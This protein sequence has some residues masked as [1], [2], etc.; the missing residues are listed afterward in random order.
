LPHFS[1][2][3]LFTAGKVPGDAKGVTTLLSLLGRKMWQKNICKKY[4]FFIITAPKSDD[5][6]GAKVHKH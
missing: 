6:P 5:F 4:L 1:A 2:K 3:H